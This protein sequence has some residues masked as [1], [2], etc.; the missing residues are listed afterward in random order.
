MHVFIKCLFVDYTEELPKQTN[1]P[2]NILSLVTRLCLR[3]VYLLGDAKFLLV[4]L[5]NLPHSPRINH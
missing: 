3:N 5:R 4:L 1:K 2:P